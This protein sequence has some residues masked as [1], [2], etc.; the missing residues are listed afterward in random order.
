M[1]SNGKCQLINN[2]KMNKSKTVLVLLTLMLLYGCNSKQIGQERSALIKDNVAIFYPKSFNAE[3]HLP[4]FSLL[5][6]PKEIG[7]LPKDWKINVE[8]S[9][10]GDKSV[11][12]IKS[13]PNTDYYGTGEVTGDLLRNGT[14]RTLWNTDN[15]RYRKERG[16]RLYQSHPWVLAVRED[17]TAYGI[18]SDNTW[19]QEL[20]IGDGI[21]FISDAPPFRVIVIEGESPQKVIKEL[22]DL[23]G[24]MPLPPLWSL[25][26]QQCRYSYYPQSRVMEIADTFRLK[27]IPCDVIWVDI[28][29]MDD[30]RV[31]TFSP[32]DFPNPEKVN[33]H[34]HDQGF[35]SVWMI[36]PGV[37][38]EKG[39]SVYDS[40]TE[41]DVWVKS[42][43]GEDYVGQVWPGDVVFPDYTQPKT[44]EWWAELY[45]DFMATGIDGVWNDMGEPSD[46][47]GPDGT[48]P[49]DNIHMGGNGIK[50]DS[51]ERYHNVYGM[52]M[53]KASRE[54]VQRANPDKRPFILT[55]S[56][57]LGGHRYAA[58]WTGDNES[59]WEQLRVSVPMSIN[60]GLSGQAFNGPDIGGFS[61]NPTPELFAHWIALGAFYPFSRVHSELG[62]IAHEPWAFGKEIEDVS[63]TALQRRYRLL[64][65]VY[66]LFREA[67]VNGMPVMRPAFFADIEEITFLR[68][69]Q[70]AFMLGGDL[71]IVPKWAENPITP[72]WVEEDSQVG[73]EEEAE[74]EELEEE[75]E[76]EEEDEVKLK[77]RSISL[78]GE[79]SKN[80]TY[81]PDILLRPG[82]ILPLGDVIQN[83][84]EYNLDKLSLYIAF[85]ENNKASGT[86]YHD[87]GDGYAYKNGEYAL[88]SFKA[89]MKDN[90]IVI[91]KSTIEGDLKVDFKNVNISVI[92]DEE[93]KTGNGV[94]TKW[95]IY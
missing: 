19:R 9:S 74:E 31:F 56:N 62:T 23:V 12:Y 66:T 27:Q 89:E 37:K 3:K 20:S 72:G 55:R 26:F 17:G 48:M 32:E 29:Y 81:Q 60:L 16:Q 76:E 51:H 85:D 35:K 34:L 44:I 47:D 41:K 52:L 84:T 68:K 40:G 87:A 64:P 80:D 86:L 50:K 54:G 24:K 92:F 1:P 45:K 15:W 39:Y 33:Q 69:E 28:H 57:F 6:E 14:N 49:I 93:V 43:T 75:E 36:D 78:V 11:A 13:E 77:W 71:F 4:S 42:S 18:I 67:S 10:I 70:Q 94:F 46:F 25:G 61:A 30:Y 91:K 63:R 38:K 8:F 58:T 73:E 7:A 21:T 53:V 65:Y 82:A 79:D 59:S 83:T 22:T 2:S 95:R 5:Q 90:A 88:I